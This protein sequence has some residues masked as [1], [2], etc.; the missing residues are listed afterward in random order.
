TDFVTPT[1]ASGEDQQEEISPTV[2]EAER[3]QRL[4]LRVLAR[5]NQL[6]RER[7]MGGKQGQ[8]LRILIAVLYT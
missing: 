4:L 5:K 2:L 6:I 7:D 3:C 1:K 8:W